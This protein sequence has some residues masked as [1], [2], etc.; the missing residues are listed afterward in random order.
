MPLASRVPDVSSQPP[1]AGHSDAP[2]TAP[3]KNAPRA[4]S[5][6]L[7]WRNACVI[8]AAIAA[9]VW[10]WE[11]SAEPNLF[12]KNFGP[13]EPGQ[14]YRAGELTPAATRTVVERH[15]IELII[16]FGA[17]DTGSPEE[18]RA[19]AVAESLGVERVRL[20]L[21]G[22][23]TGDPNRYAEALR[24][25]TDPETGPVLIHCAAGTQRT[26]C[27]TALYRSIYQGWSDERAIAEA[28]DFRWDPTDEG[29]KLRESYRRWRDAIARSL[30]TG[31]PIPYD[32]PTRE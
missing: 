32:G 19:R 9:A 8:A 25:M 15:G 24:S 6:P 31:E 4:W 23:A 21:F 7:F 17:H 20:P 1:L 5:W 16:D 12:P 14:V 13:V 18:R 10:V 2:R 27:A 3:R 11:V 28:E 26:G 22:D 29:S 30:R